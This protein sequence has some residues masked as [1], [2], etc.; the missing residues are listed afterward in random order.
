MENSCVFTDGGPASDDHVRSYPDAGAD[1]DF[2]AYYDEWT[3][4]GVF[5]YFGCRIDQCVLMNL[6][7][8]G[9]PE[10]SNSQLATRLPFTLAWHSYQPILR[11][12]RF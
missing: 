12:R 5:G 11:L 10:H 2:W 1:P 4:F 6:A 9:F 8:L 3:D 7:H